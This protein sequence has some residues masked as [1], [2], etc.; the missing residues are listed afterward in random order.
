VPTDYYA[1]LGV[2]RDA[3]PEDIKRAYR[4]LARELHPDVSPDPA[5][6]ERFK[7][8]TNAYEVLSDPRKREVY[9]LGGDPLSNAGA[10]GPAGAGFG[11]TDIF[12]AFFGQAGN[13]GPRSRVRPGQDALLR[14]ELDLA[15]AVFGGRFDLQVDTAVVCPTCSGA[16]LRDGATYRTCEVCSGRGEISQVQRSFLGQVMTSRPCPRCR[17]YGTVN[18]SPCHECGG[19]GRVRTRRSLTVEVPAGVDA[20]NRPHLAGEGE[21]GPGGGPA[22]DLYVEIGVRPHP[23]FTRQGDELHCVLAVPM[24]SA[25]LGTEVA[26]E[27]LDGVET[28]VV[29]P[30]TQ[31]GEQLTL[32]GKGVPRLRGGGRGDLV[33]HLEVR[34]PTRLDARQEDLLREL[35]GLRD[36]EQGVQ[37]EQQAT[38]GGFFSRIRERFG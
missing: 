13:R 5:S 3:S 20:G 6:A 23:V 33:A 21:V 11:F 1:T 28:V 30:G 14:L 19:D 37:G 12:D 7:D 16:G 24:T 26:I 27:T 17:G 32:R 31:F 4:R 2:A 22:G 29:P 36:E 10:G 18:P 9:D 15:E 8:V 38:A 25:A 35:A 34:T